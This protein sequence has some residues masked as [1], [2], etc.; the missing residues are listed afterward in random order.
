MNFKIAMDQRLLL[1][2]ISLFLNRSTY[3]GYPILVPSYILYG[4][5]GQTVNQSLVSRFSNQKDPYSRIVCKV[6]YSRPESHDKSLDFT[7]REDFENIGH[8]MNVYFISGEN[9][10]NLSQR[11]VY[12]F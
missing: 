2:P 8:K 5:E 10:N 9:I 4:E 12:F 3:D 1:S 6:P 11:E 7:V